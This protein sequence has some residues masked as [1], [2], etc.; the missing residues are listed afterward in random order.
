MLHGATKQKTTLFILILLSIAAIVTLWLTQSR[1]R[2]NFTH[3][4]FLPTTLEKLQ[5]HSSPKIVS[6]IAFKDSNN[7]EI[8][9][10]DFLGKPIL[11][12]LWA[13]WCAPCIAEMPA[14]DQLQAKFSSEAFA[15]VALSL[16]RGGLSDIEPFWKDA[17][18]SSLK[19][20]FDTSMS[21]GQSL[22]VRGLPTTLLID[23]GGREVARLEGPAEWA[24]QDT[25]EYFQKL[26]NNDL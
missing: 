26:I 11:L 7:Q 2:D 3:S 22:G 18:I 8:E 15:V 25:L 17:K 1:P 13:T 6:P 9:L 24:N 23:K 16:D 10:A 19:K 4:N 12:N 20:Y 5:W 14:L 21:V